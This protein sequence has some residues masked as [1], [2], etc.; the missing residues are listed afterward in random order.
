MEVNDIHSW[1]NEMRVT[2]D[3]DCESEND[4]KYRKTQRKKH[5]HQQILGVARLLYGFFNI[6]SLLSQTGRVSWWR[7]EKFTSAESPVTFAT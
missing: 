4:F 1:H 2:D 5:A 7:I 3:S 6:V